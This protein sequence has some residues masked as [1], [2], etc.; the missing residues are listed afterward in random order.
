MVAPLWLHLR[1]PLLFY[2]GRIIVAPKYKRETAE[3][4]GGADRVAATQTSLFQLPITRAGYSL[5]EILASAGARLQRFV[6]SFPLM[7]G[8]SR[9]NTVASDRLPGQLMIITM[10]LHN[11]RV[12][13]DHRS[14]GSLRESALDLCGYCWLQVWRS[15]GERSCFARIASRSARV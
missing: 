10:L 4:A 1:R 9:S 3:D 11:H 8:R 6:R 7:R 14:G 13:L 2:P 5:E 12:L 15:R